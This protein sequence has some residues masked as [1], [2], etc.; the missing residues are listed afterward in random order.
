MADN[1][2]ELYKGCGGKI[3]EIDVSL[4]AHTAL[5]MNPSM[6]LPM[7]SIELLTPKEAQ[8]VLRCSLPWIYKAAKLGIL[9]SVQIPTCAGNGKRSKSMVRFKLEDV[10]AFI[11][12]YYNGVT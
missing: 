2:K 9:P 4:R 1:R 10:Q 3:L 11:Q 6:K 7:E 5:R 12:K 8:R